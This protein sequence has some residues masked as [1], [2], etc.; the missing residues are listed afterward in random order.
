MSLFT[1]ELTRPRCCGGA[2]QV[3]HAVVREQEQLL[4]VML[5]ALRSVQ[6]VRCAGHGAQQRWM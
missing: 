4:G 1:H 3:A 6:Q 5:S 2:V